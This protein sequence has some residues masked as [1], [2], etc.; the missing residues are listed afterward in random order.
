MGEFYYI[1]VNIWCF[2]M[3]CC[4]NYFSISVPQL[5]IDVVRIKFSGL[6]AKLTEIE[7]DLQP[8]TWFD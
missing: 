5:M 7:L 2:Y 8:C 4:L 3:F 6:L 1:P